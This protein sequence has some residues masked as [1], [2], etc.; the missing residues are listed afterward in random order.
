MLPSPVTRPLV[1]AFSH[2]QA[3]A[4]IVYRIGGARRGP[5]KQKVV[6]CHMTASIA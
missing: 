5:K 3:G 4:R 2:F 6:D 1:A